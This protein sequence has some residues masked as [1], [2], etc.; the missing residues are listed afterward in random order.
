MYLYMRSTSPACRATSRSCRA[1]WTSSRLGCIYDRS[2]VFRALTRC[3][4][5]DFMHR[6]V[7][8][9]ALNPLG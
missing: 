4:E 8:I 2:L 3:I 9:E 6:R 1:S 7:V 5:L